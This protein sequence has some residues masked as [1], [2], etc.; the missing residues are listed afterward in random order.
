MTKACTKCKQRK[1]KCSKTLPCEY[2]LKIDQPQGCEYRSRVKSKV[3]K[4]TER[5]ISSLKN[6]IQALEVELA[7]VSDN[8]GDDIDLK[9]TPTAA[10]TNPLIEP[11]F[12]PDIDVH[13]TDSSGQFLGMSSCVQYLT[14][15][16]QSLTSSCKSYLDHM[17]SATNNFYSREPNI[18]SSL[19]ENVVKVELLD[20]QE[21][22]RLIQVANKIIG[23]DYMFLEPDYCDTFLKSSW[24][25]SKVPTKKQPLIEYTIELLRLMAHLALGLLFDKEKSSRA[26]GLKYHGFTLSLYAELMKVYEWATSVSLVQ[27]LLYMAYFALSLNRTTFAFVIT[28]DAIRTMFT[29][30]LHKSTSSVRGNR[31]FWLCFIYDRLLAV[32]FGFP[33]MIDERSINVPIFSEV[34]ESLTATS[35]DIYHFVSQIR[36]AKITTQVI[37]KIYTRNPF[38]FLQ[39]CRTVLGQLKRWF[40]SLPIELKFDY[41]DIKTGITRATVNLHINYNYSI[42][43]ATRPVLL[44]VFNKILKGS[45]TDEKLFESR[46][47]EFILV[48]LDSCIQAAKIQSRILTSLYYDGKLANC[49][50]LD[51]HYIFNATIILVLTGYCRMLS[52]DYVIYTGDLEDLFDFIQHNLKILQVLSEYNLAASNFNEQ[53]TQLIDLLSSDEVIGTLASDRIEKPGSSSIFQLAVSSPRPMGHMDCNKE[54]NSPVDFEKFG[55]VDLSQLVSNIDNEFRSGSGVDFFLDED[56]LNF[57]GDVA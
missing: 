21:A 18:D 12:R 30:G 56:F 17:P 51:C 14:K 35:L 49:S 50:F 7:K 11:E 13:Q 36:L 41:N 9:D 1:K 31:V 24:Y 47:F 57:P 55:F 37:T 25:K 43:I 40:D 28:G 23:A 45:E 38:S 3:A 33:L 32:R 34:D 16:K 29:L 52:N 53:L 10:E 26:L 46:Q 2:C 48:L 22:D 15:L 4:V 8:N 20:V 39:N 54:S 42:I 27:S 44:F 6:R 19:V 5:Y